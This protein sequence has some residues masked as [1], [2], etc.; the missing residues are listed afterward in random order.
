MASR[1]SWCAFAFPALAICGFVT[2]IAPAAA[3]GSMSINLVERAA[4]EIALHLGPK[5]ESDSAGDILIITNEIY[6][7]ANKVKVGSENGYCIRT[8]PGKAF[9]CFWTLSLAD[10]QITNEGTYTDGKDSVYAV[11]GGT[12]KYMNAR[13][14]MHLHIRNKEGTEN[15]YKYSLSLSE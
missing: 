3:A 12:G 8:V 6:D 11:T 14:E 5:G 15:D 1:I 13:G 10:G 2:G 7:E 9:E 4:N